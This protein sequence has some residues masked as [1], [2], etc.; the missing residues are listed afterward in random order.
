LIAYFLDNDSAKNNH[1]KVIPSEVC[2]MCLAQK[3][4][5]KQR[6]VKQK[7]TKA[8]SRTIFVSNKPPHLYIRHWQNIKTRK[9]DKAQRVARQACV[10]KTAFLTYLQ[11]G[12][13][14]AT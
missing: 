1:V 12:Y 2:E 5:A 14:T 3:G 4:I 6:K 9:W 7:G 8:G 10:N 13:A 11:T